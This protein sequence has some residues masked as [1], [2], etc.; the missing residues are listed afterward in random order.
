MENITFGFLKI[1]AFINV[2]KYYFLNVFL[3]DK[4]YNGIKMLMCNPT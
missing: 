4:M 3:N 2:G 1:Q